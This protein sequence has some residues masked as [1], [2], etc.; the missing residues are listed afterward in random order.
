MIA[1]TSVPPTSQVVEDANQEEAE[2]TLQ[3]KI[4]VSRENC[5]LKILKVCCTFENLSVFLEKLITS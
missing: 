1:E 4:K 5:N 2:R 3:K